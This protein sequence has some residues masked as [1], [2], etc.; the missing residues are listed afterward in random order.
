LWLGLALLGGVMAL[1]IL[2]SSGATRLAVKTATSNAALIERLGQP[3]KTGIFIRGEVEVTP[4][5]GKADLAIPI[6]G[7]KGKGTV[8]ALAV[9]T[10]GIWKLTLLQFGADGDSN[11]IQ[12]LRQ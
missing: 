6:S 4:G 1:V 7:P 5:F 9:K 12:L 11:R 8:Y 2:H 3:L 10:A